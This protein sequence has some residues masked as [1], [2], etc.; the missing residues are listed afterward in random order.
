[1]DIILYA[2]IHHEK[3]NEL[4]IDKSQLLQDAKQ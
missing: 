1:M 2:I 3:R 4:Q